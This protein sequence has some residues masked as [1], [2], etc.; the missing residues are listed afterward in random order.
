MSENTGEESGAKVDVGGA[1]ILSW[2]QSAGKVFRVFDGQDSGLVSYGLEVPGGKWFV[3]YADREPQISHL[4]NA[5]A[6]NSVV[7]SKYMP[8]PLGSLNLASGYALV[9]EWV[10]GE[11][12]Y[13]PEF[14]GQS[15]RD[16]PLSPYYRFVHL[17]VSAIIDVLNAVYELHA[18]IESKGFV[19]VDFYD[20]CIIYDF[21]RHRVH[22]CD[23]DHYAKGPFVLATD[24]LFGSSRFMAPEESVR[25]SVID[26]RTNVYTMGAAAFAFLANAS[27]AREHWRATDQ[28]FEVAGKAASQDR[29]QR[30]ESINQFYEEWKKAL[31]R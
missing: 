28:L 17:P 27:R 2:L 20:G 12:L 23:F 11:V 10:D 4:R 5:E 18:E 21:S 30:H 13:S 6:F 9:Y 8:R 25:G 26:H 19:A 22:F 29:G 24:R 31:D 16:N 7:K 14:R 1:D 3:K 15:G